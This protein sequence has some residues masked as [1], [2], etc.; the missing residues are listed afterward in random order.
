MITTQLNRFTL[1]IYGDGQLARL[2]AVSAKSKG[3]TPLIYTLNSKE[4]PCS[5]LGTLFEGKAWN[6]KESFLSFITCCETVVLENEFVPSSFLIE[7]QGV[8]F[9]PNAICYEKISNKLKQVELAQNLG[10][11][12]PKSKLIQNANELEGVILPLMLKSLNGGYDGYGNF[13]FK[14]LAQ[15][16]NAKRFIEKCGY[17]LAQEF[18]DFDCEVAVIVAR[19][20]NN[21]FNFPI[22][23]TI[24]ENN[25]CHYTIS[26]PRIS[27]ELQN[28]VIEAAKKLISSIDGIGVFGV[29]FF[30]KDEDVI[31]NEIAPRAH[32]S[33]HFT[34]EACNYSQFDALICL[35]LGVPFGP[36]EIKSPAAGM[37]NL[38][39]TQDGAAKFKG[40]DKFHDKSFGFLHL[41]GKENSRTGR[42]MGHFTLLGQDQESVLTELKELKTR[43]SI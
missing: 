29:E 26:P 23:E 13:T 36:L 4:S 6:D 21:T 2:L 9:I 28:K 14:D 5:G 22:V 1:G 39:G 40:D 43:Y 32:N 42:K 8:N 33:G 15:L 16:P 12:I 38:L 18:L 3:L 10:I 30:I 37:L 24:Q 27:I 19:D 20:K 11:K 41:Y 25:I 7:T 34:I 31:F 35:T 17:S